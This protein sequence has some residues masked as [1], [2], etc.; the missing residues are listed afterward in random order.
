MFDIQQAAVSRVAIGDQ[1]RIGVFDDPRDAAD[2]IGICRKPGVGQ[3]EIGCNRAITGH[4]DAG[5]VECIGD[6]G[7]YHF[8]AARQRR[9]GFCPQAPGQ[10]RLFLFPG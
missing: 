7:G 8:K 10:R 6:A 5:K 2:H 9:E 4:V 3:T 1:R